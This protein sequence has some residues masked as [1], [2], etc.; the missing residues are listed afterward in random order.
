MCTPGAVVVDV[1]T[2]GRGVLFMS[3]EF[4]TG[5]K[6][7]LTHHEYHYIAMNAIRFSISI[8]NIIF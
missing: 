1:S 3:C 2:C 5:D 7:G 8:M 6:T 4:G